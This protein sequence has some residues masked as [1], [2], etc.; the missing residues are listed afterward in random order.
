[1][2]SRRA[3][4]S[5]IMVTTIQSLRALTGCVRLIS[6]LFDRRS[7]FVRPRERQLW[8]QLNSSYMSDEETDDEEGGFVVQH[9]EWRSELLCKLIRLLDKRYEA[10]RT[11]KSN[12]KPRESRRSGSFSL[13]V[14]PKDAPKWSLANTPT[15]TPSPHTP[16]THTESQACTPETAPNQS[17]SPCTINRPVPSTF[18]TC[19]PSGPS[20]SATRVQ[21]FTSND[22]ETVETNAYDDDMSDVDEDEDENDLYSLIRTAQEAINM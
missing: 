2:A 10:S 7:K 8:M 15:R 3:K 20:T 13:R 6:Q 16:S 17:I 21:L 5:N 22:T 11:Q 18:T 1:M 19:T 12:S 9:L 4:V 14:P